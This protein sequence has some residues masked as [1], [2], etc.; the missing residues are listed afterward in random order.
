MLLASSAA[1]AGALEA[2]MAALAAAGVRVRLLPAREAVA[3]EPSLALPPPTHQWAC[4]ASMS[5][6]SW[7]TAPTHLCSTNNTSALH[8]FVFVC[9]AMLPVIRYSNVFFRFAAAR[10]V[11]IETE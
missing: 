7:H 10:S 3:L 2:R 1:E 5:L 9:P 11:S 8:F 4:L 6:P